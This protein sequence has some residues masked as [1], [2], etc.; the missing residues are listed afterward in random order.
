LIKRVSR[1]TQIKTIEQIKKN[2]KEG[3]TER[4]GADNEMKVT[5]KNEIIVK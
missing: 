2:K 5:K 3:K 1:E 4:R